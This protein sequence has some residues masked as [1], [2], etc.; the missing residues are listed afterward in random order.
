MN[1]DIGE[2]FVYCKDCN[3]FLHSD[4]GEEDR[5]VK[6]PYNCETIGGRTYM[7]IPKGS[8]MGRW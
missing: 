1:R 3:G 5:L 8:S 4:D 7:D 2:I 6:C